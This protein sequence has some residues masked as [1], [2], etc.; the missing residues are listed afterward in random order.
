VLET[1]INW[2]LE[3][4]GITIAVVVSLAFWLGSTLARLD[5][6]IT[7]SSQKTDKVYE[8]VLTSSDSLNTR[9]KVIESK[10]D[11]I[12]KKLPSSARK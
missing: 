11:D 7:Q 9:T 6:T 2:L 1:K 3:A 4:S 8:V 10:L 12:D 5:T